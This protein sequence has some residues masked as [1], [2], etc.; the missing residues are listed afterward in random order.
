M[1]RFKLYR[2]PKRFSYGEWEWVA[3]QRF[4][5]LRAKNSGDLISITH[6]EIAEMPKELADQ[7]SIKYVNGK[8]CIYYTLPFE[9]PKLFFKEAIAAPSC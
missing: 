2:R 5:W 6:R 7:L 8:V 1:V 4:L 3:C 9:T